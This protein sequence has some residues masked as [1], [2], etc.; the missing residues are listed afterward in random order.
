MS[1]YDVVIDSNEAWQNTRLVEDL[2]KAGYKVA[3]QSLPAGDFYFHGPK[4]PVLV[5][6]KTSRDFANSVLDDRLWNQLTKLKMK[7]KE[8]G[9]HIILLI[10]GSWYRVIERTKWNRASIIG[11]ID[12]IRDPNGWNIEI[13]GPFPS[14]VW[15]SAWIMRR[16]KKSKEIDSKTIY[17]LRRPLKGV[18]S[19]NER[20]RFLIE[21]LDGVG[22]KSA[23]KLLKHFGSVANV[24]AN[25]KKLDEAPKI[26]KAIV[27][28]NAKVVAGKY[29]SKI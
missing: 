24:F 3:I 20:R 2:K 4:Q 11:I 28:K 8:L 26:G 18:H 9:C 29:T 15:T 6:R 23:D 14:K 7:Q 25:I 17:A 21:G 16:A 13:L 27:E 22:P 19:D 10:E 5:E 12:S 1:R